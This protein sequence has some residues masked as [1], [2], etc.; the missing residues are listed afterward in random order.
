MKN[1]IMNNVYY[2]GIIDW[3]LRNFHGCSTH[4]GSTY[5]SYLVLDDKIALIDNVKA[6]FVDEF[7]KNIKEVIGTKKIDYL[8]CNHLEGDHTGTLPILTKKYPE[9]QIVTSE[10][11]KAGFLRMYKENWAIQTV[12]EGDTISL[13]NR[14]LTFVP[15]PMIHWP[16]S[17]V[18]YMSPDNILFSNDAFG[19]HYATSKRFDFENPMHE[20]MEEAAKYYANIVMHVSALIKKVL[21]KVTQTLQLQID[22]IFPSHGILWKDNISDILTAYTKWSNRETKEKVL[23]IYD[24]MWHSTE[25]MAQAILEGIRKEGVEAKLYNLTFTDNSDIMTEVLDARGL[26]IGS[27]T[28]NMGIFPTVAAFLTYLKGLKPP[29][30]VAAAFGSYGW[31]GKR[32]M[33]QVN[34][35]LKDA[36][37]PEILEPLSFNFIP[38]PEDLESCVTFGRDFAK[39]IKD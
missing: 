3:N 22:A 23:I 9:A 30:K 15:V 20:I 19:Q 18:T 33:E 28:L 35:Y 36:L 26:L 34:T 12:K 38:D 25:K 2:V 39:K 7:L 32:T 27:P 17:M 4:R 21:E 31:N 29:A 10:K 11:G 24:T 16:D 5:N 13:G 6:P 37:I 1:E 8:I 14:T